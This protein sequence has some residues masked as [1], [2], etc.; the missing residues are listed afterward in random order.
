MSRFTKGCANISTVTVNPG[1]IGADSLC[2]ETAV[3]HP[4]SSCL[5]ALVFSIFMGECGQDGG[6]G[7]N[8]NSCDFWITAFLLLLPSGPEPLSHSS[9]ALNWCQ[10]IGLRGTTRRG[11]I[12]KA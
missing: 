1:L 5:W 7:T 4:T 9:R 2:V 8:Q 6:M 11:V 10:A 3:Q 12:W